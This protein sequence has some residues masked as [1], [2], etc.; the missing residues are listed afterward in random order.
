MTFGP[1][2]Y[3]PVLK[4][5]RGE[6]KALQAV[7]ASL[8]AR[9]TPLLEVVKRKNEKTVA[10]HIA[11][12]FKGFQ[13][14]V[15]RYSR[16]FIDAREMEPDGVVA[17]QA[18]FDCAVAEGVVFTPVTGITRT[19]DVL[20]SLAHAGNGLAIRLTR[21]EFEDGVIPHGLP[22][23]MVAHNLNPAAVDLI[24]DLGPVNIMVQPGVRALASAFLNSVPDQRLWRTFAIS[25][26]A[27]PDSMG[28]VARASHDSVE[29]MEWNMWRQ[30]LH[31]NRG[32]LTRL[33]TFSDCGI[34]H[35]KGVED[36]DF[37]TMQP[38]AAIRYTLD[39]VWLLIKGVST[40][41]TPPSQQFPGLADQLVHGHLSHSFAGAGHCPGCAGIQNAADGEA[42][43]GSLE[44]W[45]RLGTI[46]HLTT[47]A[48]ALA[49]LP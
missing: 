15:H 21:K 29:R 26:C 31:A 48:Q 4:A 34:Q 18:V 46:H 7:A 13:E 14:A 19:A 8:C 38:S 12:S 27:F 10:I 40:K 37:R 44:T 16:C 22:Q 39:Q 47:V 2:H 25:A 41:L 36:F 17:A 24:V 3:V 45:R 30:D 33:P 23:F 28:I 32:T 5:K 11:T 1:E 6:K 35:T 43:L 20:P 49:A 42:G 9:I